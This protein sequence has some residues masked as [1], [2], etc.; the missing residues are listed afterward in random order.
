MPNPTPHQSTYPVEEFFKPTAQ[1]Q[2]QIGMACSKDASNL[3]CSI[4][5]QVGLFFD[6]TNNNM[7][8]DRDGVRTGVLD[9]KTKQPRPIAKKPL[10]PEEYSHS[11]VARL[12]LAYPDKKQKSGFFSY[13]IQGVG[14]PFEEIKELTESTNGKAF[15]KGGQ[16]RIIWGLLQLLNAIYGTSHGAGAFLYK[17]GEVGKLAQDY[18]QKVGRQDPNSNHKGAGSIVTAKQWFAP[19][20]EKLEA[21]L[22]AR[23]KPS[24]PAVKVSV[25]GFSRGA[26]E[27][28]SF[29]HAFDE[30]LE[31][32]KLA[33]V[34]AS[35]SFLGVFDT[36]ASVG[37]SASI[38][39]T[40]P[41]PG[42]LF[43][44]HWAWANCILKPLPDCVSAG[45]HYIAAHEQRMNFPV[46]RLRGNIKEFFFPGVHSDVG[47]GYAPGDQG[48]GR[49]AQAAMLSQI[50]L[51]HMY[52]AARQAG[53]P[54]TPFSLLEEREKMDFQVDAQLASAW[55]AYTAVL[56]QHGNLLTQ[57]MALFYRWR[58]SRLS[59]LN[60]APNFL[61]ANAQDQEDLH[62]ANVMLA[63]DLEAVRLRNKG[64]PR[65]MATGRPI[66]PFKS[67]DAAR[68]N[69]WQFNRAQEGAGLDAWELSA[70]AHFDQPHDLPAEVQRFFDDYVH[71]SYAGF[72]LAGEVT[73]YDK[74]E[75]IDKLLKAK[76][77]NSKG[78]DKDVLEI[79]QKTQKAQVKHKNG[80]ALTPEEAALV[81][82]AEFGT[83]YPLM[84]DANIEVG[85]AINTQTNSRREGGGYV[86]RRGYY[87]QSGFFIRKSIHEDELNKQ[88][89]TVVQPQ[90]GA[91]VKEARITYVWSDN[92]SRD[93]ALARNE[94]SKDTSFA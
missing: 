9:P 40:M 22:A 41:L 42:A 65:E 52:K 1:E 63:G 78:F 49:G 45:V 38:A 24:I 11:N 88:P 34:A 44:G 3:P 71:D 27:A 69:Q 73:E 85:T 51:A 90:E 7:Y 66:P 32:G 33:G 35:I 36:V 10:K 57:H 64:I 30:L 77:E 62:A 21:A 4:P 70:L 76:P 48:K 75:K 59:T 61:A 17:S 86:L 6:G 87:P 29:C 31:G 54:L 19:H 16:P 80:V 53:V 50:P 26:A 81:K 60:A 18:D 84:T 94:A 92:L 12:F 15:A 91:S 89:G 25:F 79:T 5:V 74:R 39:K 37:G 67:K 47:G 46:T 23:P 83:P 13:Y 14:T 20:L 68:M 55:N 43:D 28:V 58:A 2:S 72:Y 82:E 93:I 8:R 56:G